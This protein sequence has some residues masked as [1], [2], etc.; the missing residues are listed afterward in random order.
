[1]NNAASHAVF[2]PLVVI[3]VYNHE[4]AIGAMVDG[5]RM[6]APRV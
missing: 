2:K 4:Q 5:V 1:M 6:H 3:P